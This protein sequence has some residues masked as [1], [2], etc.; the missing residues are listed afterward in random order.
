LTE[1]AMLSLA[2]GA[3]GLLI[4]SFGTRAAL[5]VVPDRL[6]RAADIH[7]SASVLCF[8]LFISLASGMLFGLAPALRAFRQS[9]VRTLK[10]GGRGGSETRHRTQDA[11]VI[12][13]MALALVLLAGAGL[14]IRSMMKLSDVDPGFRAQNVLTF[15]VQAPPAVT[16]NLDTVRAYLHE[17]ERRISETPGV[18]AASLSWAALPLQSDDEQLFWLDNEPKP[19]N[20]NAMHW[21]IRYIVGPGYLKAMSI[22][23]LRGRFLAES[24]DE[25]APRALVVDDVFAHKFFGNEDPIGKRVHMDGFDDPAVIVG[26]VGHVN[27]WGLDSDA[28]NSLRAETYQAM[29]QLPDAQLG[30]VPLGMDVVVRSRTDGASA[31]KSIQGELARMNHE[32]VAYNFETM[33][34]VIADSL[35]SRRFSMI[36]LS[37]F[38][39]IALLLASV[40]MYGVISYVVSQ[41]TQEIGIRMALGADRR[42]V[43]RWVVGQGGRL[44]MIGAVAGLMAA[45][46]LT[47]VMAHSALLYGVHAYD[48]WTMACVTALLI[49]VALGACYVPAR[50]A[51]QVDPMKA[52]RAE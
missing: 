51:T 1:S 13:Q 14:V 31:F 4:A 3:L 6:P 8:T 23:L 9:P 40:G 34:S 44:A 24:D 32:Q 2:G 41:R 11:L 48:P 22:P 27:Q 20:E 49:L 42:D 5:K 36:L 15:G 35:A 17:V 21:S 10:E 50:R 18:E 25:H 45:L 12:L 39:G 28:T 47:Q 43:L 52:L 30:L 33:D 37:V 26:V 38:A 19:A 7:M 46:A 16:A 29:L